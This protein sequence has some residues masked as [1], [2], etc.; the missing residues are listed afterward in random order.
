LSERSERRFS[1]V[2]RVPASTANLG[3]GFDALGLAV[4][5]YADI[6]ICDPSAPPPPRRAQVVGASHPAAI[7]FRRGGG[8]GGLWVR[9]PIPMGRGLGFS[10]AMRVG[11]LVAA[12][13]Q[14]AGAGADLDADRAGLL[15]LAIELEGHGDNVAASLYGG[16]VATAAGRAVVV[17]LA[18]EPAVVAWVPSFSTATEKSRRALP[19]TVPFGDAVFNIGRTALL[20][21]ALAAGDVHALRNATGDRLHQD[22]RMAEAEPSRQALNAGLDAGAWCGW[23]SGSGPT[24]ALLCAP[25]DADAIGAALPAEG[26]VKVLGVDLEGATLLREV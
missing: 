26:A 23:L 4:T 14:R 11:G 24:V 22:L 25:G 6:G 20:V 9:S 5:L 15:Q 10:G 2:T 21:A 7:A 19:A 18:I 13:A 1:V 8:E 3:P 12:W 17:P 16:V